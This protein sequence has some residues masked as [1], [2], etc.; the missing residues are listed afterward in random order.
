MPDHNIKCLCHLLFVRY[1]HSST[2]AYDLRSPPVVDRFVAAR[3]NSSS[4]SS[5]PAPISLFHPFDV[6][7]ISLPTNEVSVPGVD[8]G[9][10][11]AGADRLPL[12]LAG[13][14]AHAIPP[15]PFLAIFAGACNALSV[16]PS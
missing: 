2:F 4:P 9:E 3:S 15:I 1:A 8:R 12:I 14:G 10:D 5:D 7:G 11:L 6:A 16:D 13:A